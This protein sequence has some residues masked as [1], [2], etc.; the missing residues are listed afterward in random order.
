VND[1]S[2]E[3]AARF[4]GLLR[5][6]SGSDRLRMVSDMFETAR[7]LV[8]ANVRAQQPD[9]SALELRAQ[10]FRRLYASDFTTEDLASIVDRLK[11]RWEESGS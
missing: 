8:I 2:P 11:A 7:A 5:K 3:M 9:I 10:V 6:R 4:E 1:T